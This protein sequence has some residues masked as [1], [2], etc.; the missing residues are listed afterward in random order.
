MRRTICVFLALLCELP[1]WAGSA[2]LGIDYIIARSDTGVFS[3]PSQLA[4]MDLSILPS[5]GAHYTKAMRRDL[6]GRYGWQSI[7]C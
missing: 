1:V 3:R 4:T 6:D 5:S 2:P 7:A